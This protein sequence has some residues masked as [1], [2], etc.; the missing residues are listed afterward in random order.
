MSETEIIPAAEKQLAENTNTVLPSQAIISR[1]VGLAKLAFDAGMYRDIRNPQQA[2]LRI[3]MGHELGFSPM[4]S[5]QGI[6]DIKGKF[7][8]SAHLIATAIKRSD[9]YRY[10]VIKCN[11]KI[12][13]IEFKEFL[14]G[15]WQLCGENITFTHE[16]GLL[17]KG[18]P[19]DGKHEPKSNWEKSEADMLY[20]RCLTR[21]QRRYCPDVSH[22]FVGA[23]Y[24]PE[25]LDAPL[26][27]DGSVDVDKVADIKA[28][29][30]PAASSEPIESI[31]V[32][33]E[34]V[35]MDSPELEQMKK[36]MTTEKARKVILSC[37]NSMKGKQI[38]QVPAVALKKY[39]EKYGKSGS[40]EIDELEMLAIRT[41]IQEQHDNYIASKQTEG[42]SFEDDEVPESFDESG[43]PTSAQAS[44]AKELDP[45]IA[46]HVVSG[47]LYD[48]FRI[49]DIG[50]ASLKKFKSNE[51][52]QEG[53]DSASLALMIQA[54]S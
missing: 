7:S 21:G 41:Y 8:F 43:A 14:D 10:K 17:L 19:E 50:S 49:G 37:G 1:I 30:A 9:R 45:T 31:V 24:T 16:E 47:G 2:F 46:D 34:S 6:H 11:N 51:A 15:E 13:E 25:E 40:D 53:T 27:D 32:D 20:A 23:M 52:M 26:L 44:E 33:V 3:M 35:V 39:A 38:D 22:T 54:A 5:L 18:L 36:S 28:K 48:G 12:C 29:E 4:T 42:T